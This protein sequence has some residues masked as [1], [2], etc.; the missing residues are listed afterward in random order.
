MNGYRRCLTVMAVVAP[1]V[2]LTAASVSAGGWLAQL[3]RGGNSATV[4]I[5]I[6]Q[7]KPTPTE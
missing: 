4:A 1:V 5:Q 7:A 3:A 6:S 2:T